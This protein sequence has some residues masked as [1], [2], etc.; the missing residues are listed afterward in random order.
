VGYLSAE[1]WA[2]SL[3]DAGFPEFRVFPAPEHR[4][5]WPYGGIVAQRPY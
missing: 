3:V 5:R 1:E 2:L 4:E